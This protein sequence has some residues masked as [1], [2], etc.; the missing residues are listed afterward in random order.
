M[1][2]MSPAQFG[3]MLLTQ[4]MGSDLGN[5][6]LKSKIAE[7]VKSLSKSTPKPMSA[8][9]LIARRITNVP[10]MVV[11]K[12]TITPEQSNISPDGTI[13]STSIIKEIDQVLSRDGLKLEKFT[14]VVRNNFD[15]VHTAVSQNGMALQF[16]SQILQ[17]EKEIVLAAYKQNPSSL[18]FASPALREE[19]LP[20]RAGQ[21]QTLQKLERKETSYPSIAEIQN[22]DDFNNFKLYDDEVETVSDKIEGS[23]EF[24]GCLEKAKIDGL[25]IKYF[26]EAYRYNRTILIEAIK[27]NGLAIQFA[28]LE[29]RGDEFLMNLAVR[30]DGMAIQYVTG[31]MITNYNLALKAVMQNGLALQHVLESFRTHFIFVLTAVTQNGFAIEFADP[32]LV[33]NEEIYLAA[34][35]Q[36]W[37]T[38]K[39]LN[40]VLNIHKLL[41]KM[42]TIAK[43]SLIL[44]AMKGEKMIP[45]RLMQDKNYMD[46]VSN[47]T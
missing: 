5:D 10:K 46:I 19:I 40:Q 47:R 14:D 15:F 1:N 8:S 41:E 3:A 33:R 31:D 22:S 9:A 21:E 30:Q 42:E 16:A 36:N 23:P 28:K 26:P 39:P 18:Q 34:I 43:N 44:K 17:N 25:S 38:Y 37:A 45:M 32:A 35:N 6:D 13:K 4:L 2:N 29:Q 27:Q 24:R 11:D 7:T 20:T 12:T